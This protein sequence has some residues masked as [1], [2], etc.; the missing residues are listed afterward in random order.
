MKLSTISAV[1]AAVSLECVAASKLM[2]FAA[3]LTCSEEAV[4]QVCSGCDVIEFVQETMRS[5][6][7]VEGDFT[8]ITSSAEDEKAVASVCAWPLYEETSMPF[9]VMHMCVDLYVCGMGERGRRVR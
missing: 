5:G 9:A 7:S 2:N 8:V 3:D 1:V 6:P 4:K